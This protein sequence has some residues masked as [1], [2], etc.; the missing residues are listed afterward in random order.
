MQ[1]DIY[2]RVSATIAEQMEKHGANWVNPFR[3]PG[4]S[5]P[6]NA[7]TGAT[8]QGI[9][10]ILL[11][12]AP[13]ET[14][15]YAGFSQWHSKGCHVKKGERGTLIVFYSM[16]EGRVDPET[17]KRARF[18][19][20]KHSY[21]FNLS[22][23]EGQYADD[24]RARM[25]AP[26]GNS[27]VT[28]IAAADAW[29]ASV[30]A[31]V[32]HSDKAMAYYSPALDYIHMPARELFSDTPTSTATECYYSTL[33]HELTHWT[34]AKGRCDRDLLN[35][36]GSEKYAA[37]ELVAE[38]GAAFICADL[39]ISSEP[40]PDHAQYIAGWISRIRD[41][42]R[43]FMRAVGE[44]RRAMAYLNKKEADEAVAA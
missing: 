36:F 44:A 17:G 35:G 29:F 21:V 27:S 38:L 41:D 1:A 6:V 11:G 14:V 32:R 25:A 16:V 13:F 26:A 10:Q 34:G 43:A 4:Y 5:V 40:R 20:L 37:E 28:A 23:V 31:D 9:N 30:G 7:V 33:A 8:Y 24:L 2:E 39:G 18:P 12:F 15:A 22:Q 42:K 19:L 3:R